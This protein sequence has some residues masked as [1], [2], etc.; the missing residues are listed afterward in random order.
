MQ[1]GRASRANLDAGFFAR[2]TVGDGD[3]ILQDQQPTQACWVAGANDSKGIH[4]SRTLQESPCCSV[5]SPRQFAA[6]RSFADATFYAASGF[7][8][9]KILQDSTVGRNNL[10]AGFFAADAPMQHI[11]QD[12]PCVEHA[13]AEAARH[14]P[15]H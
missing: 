3:M 12:T 14:S 8:H 5:T 9:C 15:M 7:H 13:P 10:D 4:R 1:L 11:L 2:D 6:S